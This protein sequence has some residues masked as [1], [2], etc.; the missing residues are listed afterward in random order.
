MCEVQPP[1]LDVAT[2]GDEHAEDFFQRIVDLRIGSSNRRSVRT[3]LAV[4][5]HL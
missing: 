5:P 4:S 3:P 2:N 1:R